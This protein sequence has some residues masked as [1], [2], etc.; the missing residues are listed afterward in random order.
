MEKTSD[1][2]DN[3]I[4][5]VPDSAD[6]DSIEETKNVFGSDE[7]QLAKLGYK[8]EFFRG[9]GDISLVSILSR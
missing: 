1:N 8:Q 3:S 5:P 9:L 6:H 2:M 4:E 7:Y